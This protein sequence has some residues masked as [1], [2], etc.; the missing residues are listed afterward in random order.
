MDVLCIV[1]IVHHRNLDGHA[2][3]LGLQVDDIVEEVGAV[4]VH[5]AHELLQ[6]VL[7]MEH[8]LLGLAFLVG[9]E[10]G[11]GNLDA[12]V[13]ECQL[14]HTVGDDVPLVDGVGEDGGV[15][16]ELLACTALLGLADNL[17]GVEGLALLVLLLVDLSVTEHL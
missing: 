2:L 10:V 12:C 8:L 9:T 4:A 7:G 16:P 17:H 1:R 3:L 5:I 13:E 14:T 6:T 15:W 11:Q